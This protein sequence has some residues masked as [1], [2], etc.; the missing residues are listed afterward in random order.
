MQMVTTF[1]DEGYN[2]V[3]KVD[4]QHECYMASATMQVKGHINYN[5]CMTGR[6]SS[7]MKAAKQMFFK[8]QACDGKW[9]YYD[10]EQDKR[11]K[12]DD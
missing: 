2:V 5:I 6:G 3:F 11:L 1:V 12:F 7:P 4:Q 10:N 8:H 9:P